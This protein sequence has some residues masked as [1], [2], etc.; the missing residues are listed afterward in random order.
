MTV[1]FLQNADDIL[2]DNQATSDVCQQFDKAKHLPSGTSSKEQN[3]S[4]PVEVKNTCAPVKVDSTCA[5]VEIDTTC[6][7]VE[8]DMTCALA[9]GQESS[10]EKSPSN[11]PVS[12]G[13]KQ[14]PNS[15]K[16]RRKKGSLFNR[17]KQRKEAENWEAILSSE[18]TEN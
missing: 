3:V 4:S 8:V 10:V 7:P 2:I 12:P 11:E 17:K 18:E 1:S 6:A 14:E 13:S 15:K 16:K 9:V 5:P